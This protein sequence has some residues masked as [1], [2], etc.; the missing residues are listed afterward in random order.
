MKPHR[1]SRKHADWST[2]ALGPSVI[3]PV[4]EIASELGILGDAKSTLSEYPIIPSVAMDGGQSCASANSLSD[5]DADGEPDLEA[6]SISQFIARRERGVGPEDGQG[7]RAPQNKQ[8]AASDAGEESRQKGSDSS[9][10]DSDTSDNGGTDG[11]SNG[12]IADGTGNIGQDE[13]GGKGKQEKEEEEDKDKEEDEDEEEEEDEDKEEEDEDKEEEEDEDKEEEEDED[14]EEEEDE[15]KEE[16]DEDKDMDKDKDQ[17]NEDEEEVEEEAEDEEGQDHE[18]NKGGQG[19]A[20]QPTDHGLP[21][22]LDILA[23]DADRQTASLPAAD[24]GSSATSNQP[25]QDEMGLLDMLCEGAADSTDGMDLTDEDDIWPSELHNFLEI[26]C[27]GLEADEK[28]SLPALDLLDELCEQGRLGQKTGA[29]FYRYD[30]QRTPKPDPDVEALI[31]R[32]SRKVG[33]TRRAIPD[34]E[35]LE[36]CLYAMINEGARILEEGIAARP[37][38]IDA[39]W[40]FGYGF[41]RHR[42]GPM[43]YADTVGLPNVVMAMQKYARGPHA[44]AWT[45]APLLKRL[46]DEGKTFN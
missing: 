20:G 7:G 43:F 22:N 31:E 13:D 18:K 5:R 1:V 6:E 25:A 23:S 21:M 32:H 45:P 27:N 29:G 40:L 39:V 38:D 15:D 41:P 19:G 16:E 2:I 46:A 12:G 36:R 24:V 42:G 4:S 44:D 35:I 3:H 37:L 17:D 26:I 14:K 30:E 9:G 11:S 34:Q 33:I 10:S 28:A 8:L